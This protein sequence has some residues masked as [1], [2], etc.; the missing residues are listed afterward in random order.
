M[1]KLFAAFLLALGLATFSLSYIAC[2]PGTTTEKA[3]AEA[4]TTQDGSVTD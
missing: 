2:S 3:P 1:K 4:V